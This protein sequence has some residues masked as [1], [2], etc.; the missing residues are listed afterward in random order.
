MD[1]MGWGC[2][3][4]GCGGYYC[5]SSGEGG[6]LGY[7]DGEDGEGI[8]SLVDELSWGEMRMVV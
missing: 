4:L 6:R 8:S 2:L 1:G 5:F 3:V 7:C